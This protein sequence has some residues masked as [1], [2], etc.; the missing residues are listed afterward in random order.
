MNVTDWD[1]ITD[2]YSEIDDPEGRLVLT[3][4]RDKLT[5]SWCSLRNLSNIAFTAL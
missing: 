4:I 3:F 2:A 1:A 5:T